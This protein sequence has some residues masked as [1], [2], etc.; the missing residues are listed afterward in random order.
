MHAGDHVAVT[1]FDGRLRRLAYA[2][3]DFVLLPVAN[4]PCGLP[5]KIGQRYGALPVVYHTT[6]IQSTISHMDCSRTILEFDRGYIAKS[7]C[8]DCNRKWQLP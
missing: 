5:C 6:A 8:K 4:D 7:P 3:A 1:D 2:A